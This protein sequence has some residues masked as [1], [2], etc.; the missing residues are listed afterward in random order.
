MAIG[1][2]FQARGFGGGHLGG[3]LDP[4]GAVELDAAIHEQVDIEIAHRHSRDDDR[5]HGYR[6]N[7][8]RCSVGRRQERHGFVEAAGSSQRHTQHAADFQVA[9]GDNLFR[10]DQEGE[11]R[12]IKE[13]NLH[14]KVGVHR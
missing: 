10:P 13:I 14:G 1:L 11:A 4:S 12:D 8:A 6:K 9:I 2:E 5:Y 7:R 3:G